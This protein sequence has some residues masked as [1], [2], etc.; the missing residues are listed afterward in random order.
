MF[1]SELVVSHLFDLLFGR[2]DIG[3]CCISAWQLLGA[4]GSVE[5][6]IPFCDHVCTY[7]ISSSLRWVSGSCSLDFLDKVPPLAKVLY[8]VNYTWPSNRQ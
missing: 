3:P 7:F 8:Q 6:A 4:Y 5:R 2:V 1:R